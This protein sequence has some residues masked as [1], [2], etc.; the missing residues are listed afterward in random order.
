MDNVQTNERFF[1][2]NIRELLGSEEQYGIGESDLEAILSEFFSPK[3][4]DIE[5]FLKKNAIEFAKKN[6]SVTYLVMSAENMDLV[7]YFTIAMKV[8]KIS[9]AGMSKM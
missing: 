1:C 3:N 4:V 6:Q 2:I 7:G 9:A 5:R 8:V